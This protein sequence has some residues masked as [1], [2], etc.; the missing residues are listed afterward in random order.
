MLIHAHQCG[1]MPYLDVNWIWE[2]RDWQSKVGTCEAIKERRWESRKTAGAKASVATKGVRICWPNKNTRQTDNIGKALVKNC[3]ARMQ[4]SGGILS[5][6]SCPPH[7]RNEQ[8]DCGTQLWGQ[9]RKCSPHIQEESEWREV[10][11]GE[12]V[13]SRPLFWSGNVGEGVKGRN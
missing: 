4:E 9:D 13:G 6:G 5:M 1:D 12:Q 3:H 10:G 2:K 11:K 7:D 8:R